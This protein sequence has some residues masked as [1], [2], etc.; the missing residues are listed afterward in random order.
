MFGNK[1]DKFYLFLD[2]YLPEKI[3]IWVEPF[4]GT[5]GLYKLFNE[6]INYSVYNE[7]NIKTFNKYKNIADE[8]YNLDYKI[9]LK[10]WDEYD[11]FFFIDPPYYG[12]EDYY[13]TKFDE[14]NE[15]NEIVKNLKSNFIM[16][17]NDC[18]FIRNLYKDFKIDTV[19]YNI[20]KKEI[21]IYK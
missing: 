4:G 16:T 6:K 15:L 5:F 20:Y 12:K 8:S 2:K 19:P 7:L 17:Y 10:K 9:I 1:Y 18:E 14:H 11:T 13:E 3:N 21:I